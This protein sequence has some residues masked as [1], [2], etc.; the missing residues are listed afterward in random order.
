MDLCISLCLYQNDKYHIQLS[1]G[2]SLESI[3]LFSETPCN[4][5]AQIIDI[6]ICSE[7]CVHQ[8]APN[9]NIKHI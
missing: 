4:F 1:L 8:T 6:K 5:R 2:S 3:Y 9:C 7:Q